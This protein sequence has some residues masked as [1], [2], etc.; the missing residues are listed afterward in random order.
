M[1]ETVS[2]IGVAPGPGSHLVAITPSD[3]TVLNPALR[4]LWIGGAGNLALLA[5]GDTVAVT[6]TVPAAGAKI[7][8][9]L[10]QKVMA[11]NTTATLITGAY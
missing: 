8:F 6:L 4:T 11:T 7:D 9:V 1:S 2:P 5:V 10:V 3:S